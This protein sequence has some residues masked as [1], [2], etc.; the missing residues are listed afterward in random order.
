MTPTISPTLSKKTF[1]PSPIWYQHSVQCTRTRRWCRWKRIWPSEQ[2]PGGRSDPVVS[3]PPET[4]KAIEA[5]I[6]K[7]AKTLLKL[8][9]GK[10]SS[11]NSTWT[12]CGRTRQTR[13]RRHH[14]PP[15]S[16]RN[17]S[18]KFSKNT[19]LLRKRCYWLT[20][21]DRYDDQITGK[22][23]DTKKSS[24]ISSILAVMSE[25]LHIPCWQIYLANQ[26]A[27]IDPE[28]SILSRV[29]NLVR[30]YG[31]EIHGRQQR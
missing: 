11:R 6:T 30:F 12:G 24:D 3:D 5:L 10:S 21:R 27:V 17:Y 13:C 4:D 8:G 29:L 19:K 26:V 7:C 20:G 9:V 22:C 18:R 23:H 16:P 1:T 28:E 14:S 31:T 2:W 15:P 25:Q